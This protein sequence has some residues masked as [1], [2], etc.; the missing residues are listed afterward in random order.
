MCASEKQNLFAGFLFRSRLNLDENIL[1]TRDF[2]E[3]YDEEHF[4]LFKNLLDRQIIF[5]KNKRNLLNSNGLCFPLFISN[6]SYLLVKF[7]NQKAVQSTA[8]FIR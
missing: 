2:F 3:Q 8:F 1:M 4:L 7:K 5:V 6:Q